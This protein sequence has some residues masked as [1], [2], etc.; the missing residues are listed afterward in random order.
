MP[1]RK[2]VPF[3]KTVLRACLLA[4]LC[5]W[6]GPAI[7][8]EEESEH[9]RLVPD[10]TLSLSNVI[11]AAANQ[12]PDRLMAAARETT[13]RAYAKHAGS[14]FA[15][16]PQLSVSHQNDFLLSD[17]GLREWEGR[18]E[19]PLWI[20][21]EKSA[22]QNRAR[23]AENEARA[24]RA[25]M[26]WN[27]AREV[28]EL[29]WQV[30]LAEAALEE[31]RKGLE[32]AEKLLHHVERRIASGD[33]PRNSLILA[34]QEV[35]ARKIALKGAERDY[36]DSAVAYQSYT[37]LEAIPAEIN[38]SPQEVED[39]YAVPP[40]LHARRLVE[41]YRA[42]YNAVRQS[43]SRSPTLSLGVK[44]ERGGF[45]DRSVDS[46]SLGISIPLGSGAHTAPK[47]AEAAARLAEAERQ[48]ERALRAQKI[49]LHEAE[50][51]LE[52]CLIQQKISREHHDMARENLQLA[53]RAFDL[54]E[55]DLMDLLRVQDQYVRSSTAHTR[56]QL[57]CGRAI[58]RHNQT[59]GLL[60]E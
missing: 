45:D 18:L 40:V 16:S 20:P 25:R 36:V 48:K 46:V 30:K 14:L 5:L 9:V 10:S 39:A 23:T 19:L 54:G 32:M 59:K 44:R 3:E 4:T 6:P 37:G 31:S 38:E 58:A 43:W 56:Q 15:D 52:V 2:T 53:Q 35:A 28:R 7:S 47:R 22:Y 12:A 57:E 8:A 33:L 13:S 60:P 11:D 50:H 29:V 26:I 17:Q 51:E 1:L 55:S 24:Y 34:R 41:Y 42:E 21:G 49:A 27:V